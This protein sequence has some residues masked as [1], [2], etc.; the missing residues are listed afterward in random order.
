[1][2]VTF[3]LRVRYQVRIKDFEAGPGGTVRCGKTIVLNH[4]WVW[5]NEIDLFD[6]RSPQ[7]DPTDVNRFFASNRVENNHAGTAGLVF[8]WSESPGW[9]EIPVGVEPTNFPGPRFDGPRFND[10]YPR[11][12]DDPTWFKESREAPCKGVDWR[13]QLPALNTDECDT[14]IQIQNVGNEF[15]KA[16]LVVWGEYGFCPPQSFGPLK[17]ECTG[18]LRP[19][20]AWTFTNPYLPPGARSGI[21]YSL[22]ATDV[23]KDERGNELLFAD[24]AC[25][26][27]F[28]LIRADHQEWLLFDRAYR[29]RGTYFGPIGDFP[30]EQL[31]LD[32]GAHS[33]EPLA[34]TVNR[35][36]PDVVDPNLDS[37][38]V[39]VGISTDREGFRDPRAGGFAY[40]APLVWADFFG[41]NSIIHVQN[42]GE[43]CTSVELWFQQQG[44][45]IRPVV[46][47]ILQLAPGE[48]YPF[49]PNVVVGPV[50]QGSVW[51]SAS[52]PLGV[53]VDTL[54]ANH[55]GS[56][57]GVPADVFINPGGVRDFTLGT[58]V[59]YAP[60]IYREHQGWE[61][62]IQVQNLS[63]IHNAKVKVSFLDNSG[64]IIKTVV[65]WI[66]PRG[67]QTFFLPVISGLPG[68]WAGSARIESQD[69]FTPGDPAIESP[70]I[71]SV[72]MLEKFTDPAKTAR[73][74][75]V[76]YNALQEMGSFDWQLGPGRG[77]FRG[78]EVL[79]IPLVAKGNRG[80]TTEIAIQN[81]NPN[82]GFTDFVIFIYDQNRLIDFVCE[83]LNEKQ[84]EYIDLNQWGY[85]PDGFLGS[86][87]ISATFTNQRGGAPEQEGVGVALGAVAVERVGRVLSE[88]DLPGDESKA[89]EAFP[90]FDN[91]FIV[92]VGP[93]GLPPM[94]PG[95]P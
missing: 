39:Y 68:Y 43:E 56:Y 15:T 3:S 60:L 1:I 35:T 7:F 79:A 41:L 23:V 36:C 59:N 9:P 82:P 85:I 52:Q 92:E 22:N 34:V 8:W 63:S 49:D 50:W 31:V 12:D 54:G 69:W 32:F 40:Y 78:A 51:L 55:F 17:V 83:K 95:Q 77:G 93:D 2:P 75:T 24:L 10:R 37:S 11:D 47:D 66:C 29:E 71:L 27:L 33:G 26:R 13:L 86:L 25:N 45:C 5:Y 18:L 20:S 48:S 6:Q 4:G 90:L 87:V 61:T 89:F 84:V 76:V 38:A 73:Q 81:L 64:D 44:D 88:P 16:L 46:W 30:G 62:S 80:V 42:S 58:Q 19:G 70:R 57:H 53:V 72:V 74:E 21:I 67:S 28:P 65:D 94:C 91:G 14:W